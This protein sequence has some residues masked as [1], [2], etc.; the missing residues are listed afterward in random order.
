[1]PG[2]M[3]TAV[4]WM[5]TAGHML[6]LVWF[7]WRTGAE[8]ARF[9]SQTGG[10]HPLG[11]TLW[12]LRPRRA[13]LADLL[14][15]GR[16]LQ[17]LRPAE[18]SQRWRRVHGKL[19]DAVARQPVA[20]HPLTES[21]AIA[22]QAA[23]IARLCQSWFGFDLP[24][25]DQYVLGRYGSVMLFARDLLVFAGAPLAT[26]TRAGIRAAMPGFVAWAELSFHQHLVLS[27]CSDGMI[28]GKSGVVGPAAVT[29]RA[30]RAYERYR[31]LVNGAE[32]PPA[33][34]APITTVQLAADAHRQ[35]VRNEAE[36]IV[37][38][39]ARNQ[40][41]MSMFWKATADLVSIHVEQMT[42]DSNG[43]L[44]E[45][46]RE[47]ALRRAEDRL[48]TYLMTVLMANFS[49]ENYPCPAEMS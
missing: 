40:I 44:V 20:V 17:T 6:A 28:P 14:F 15:P 8:V 46:R 4:R 24:H 39:M 19:Q 16:G 37:Q 22:L 34:A 43:E 13:Q 23:A 35:A 48:E 49:E 2:R 47:P 32:H 21:P 1:M 12:S 30:R 10:R 36:R 38:R 5:A 26:A 3:N 7:W 27:D 31:R 11:R 45:E 25:A 42:A 41:A 18:E 33:G 9:A 29:S